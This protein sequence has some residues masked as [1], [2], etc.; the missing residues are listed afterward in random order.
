MQGKPRRRRDSGDWC[1]LRVE[2]WAGIKA[3]SGLLDDAETTPELKLRAVSALATA[4]AVYARIL[5]G[6]PEDP[7]TSAAAEDDDPNVIV[8]KV[9]EVSNGHHSL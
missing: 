4:A 6:K 5:Q 3:A 9:S 8:V 2:L 7:H 1:Q